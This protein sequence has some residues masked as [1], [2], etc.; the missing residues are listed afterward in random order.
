MLTLDVRPRELNFDEWRLRAAAESDYSQLITEDCIISFDGRPQIVYLDLGHDPWAA[1]TLTAI[2]A[3]IGRIRYQTTNRTEGLPTTSRVFGYSPRIEIRNDFCSAAGLKSESPA[4]HDI[5]ASGALIGA[6]YYQEFDPG[7]FARHQALTTERVLPDYRLEGGAYTSGIV[8]RN[9]PL[10]Y[11][12]D[13]GN[14]ADCWSAMLGFKRH[15]AGGFLALPAYDLGFQ[16]AD[17]SLF[18]FDGATI[19]HGVTPIRQLT[20]DARRYTVVYYSLRAMWQCLDPASELRRVR[21]RKTIR[22][23][24]QANHGR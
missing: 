6:H 9:N 1:S 5:I 12:F 8:N 22:H 13:A 7:R 2:E 23:R 19:L 11:H 17:R 16:I 10:K 20:P 24:N 3:A 18:L 15:I 21:Q 4:D 14:Y